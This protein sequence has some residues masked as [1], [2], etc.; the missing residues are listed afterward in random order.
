[1]DLLIKNCKIL[2]PELAEVDIGV[3]NGRIKEMGR[4]LSSSAEE[5]LDA[6]GKLCFPGFIDTHVHFQDP[7]VFSSSDF[8]SEST[9][10]L[11][12]GVTT[13]IDMP[14][15]TP[16]LSGQAISEKIALGENPHTGSVIDF[17][18]HAGNMTPEAFARMSEMKELGVASFKGFT[19][20]PY[21]LSEE[22]LSLFLRHTK[23]NRVLA[24]FHCEDQDILD[25]ARRFVDENDINPKCFLLSRPR[26]AE[27]GAAKKI[28]QKAGQ[29]GAEA[30]AVHISTAEAGNIIASS[31][32]VSGEACLHHLI[33]TEEDMTSQGV[34]LKMNPPLRT[35]G[36][37]EALWG[38]LENRGL[39]F[40]ATD[41]FFVPKSE[42]DV[43]LWDSPAGVPG[44]DASALLTYTQGV[45]KR[46]MPLHRFQ[47]IM[48]EAQARRFGLFPRKG[49]INVGSDAD[50]V[51]F[52]PDAEGN[53][54]SKRD[55]SPYEGLPVKGRITD[56]FLRGMHKL[57]D[58]EPVLDKETID[59]QTASGMFI[60]RTGPY[61]EG[62]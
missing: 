37:V 55:W 18:L 41:H 13:F 1:M 26:E 15:D 59:G 8:R 54:H 21:K 22:E 56:V 46:N 10:A 24:M 20:D 9:S 28:V 47:E 3:K 23:E 61:P 25:D 39:D 31:P 17:S 29:T 62:V 35:K 38:L 44:I 7:A 34:K 49:V 30:H 27:V 6:G 12:G 42:K 48:S 19:C 5:V 4:S 2:K 43:G 11:R 52:D 58:G 45:V 53:F 60:P 36:D 51:L 40:V 14:T 57:V 32:L 50:L 16:T 33:F